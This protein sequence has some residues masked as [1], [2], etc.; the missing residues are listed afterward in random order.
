MD[1]SEHNPT[2]ARATKNAV[3]SQSCCVVIDGHHCFRPGNHP[4]EPQDCPVCKSSATSMP[5]YPGDYFDC[6]ACGHTWPPS[7]ED[8]RKMCRN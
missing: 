5:S 1:M 4:C 2:A 8:V 7:R 6:D 3:R